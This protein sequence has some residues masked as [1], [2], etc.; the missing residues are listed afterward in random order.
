V[1]RYTGVLG[2]INHLLVTP[3]RKRFGREASPRA[4]VTDSHSVETI[5]GGGSRGCDAAKK[6]K[7]RST[8][9][10]SF[11]NPTVA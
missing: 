4:A 9:F 3:D 6:V 2:T 8:V 7:R 5:E 10:R 1:S 11:V